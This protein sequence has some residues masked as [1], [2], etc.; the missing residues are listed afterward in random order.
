MPFHELLG[1][2]T[3]F[4]K[5]SHTEQDYNTSWKIYLIPSPPN[6][7]E[8]W[9][10]TNKTLDYASYVYRNIVGKYLFEVLTKNLRKTNF[11]VYAYYKQLNSIAS[12]VN[13]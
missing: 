5:Y 10:L 9:L 12:E 4:R 8:Q 3:Y 11:V 6:L 7:K 2:P 13:P 1:G